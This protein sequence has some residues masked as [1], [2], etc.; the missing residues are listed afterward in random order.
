M[1]ALCVTSVKTIGMKTNFVKQQ[2]VNSKHFLLLTFL[3]L[4]A[5]FVHRTMVT[6]ADSVAVTNLVTSTAAL[7]VLVLRTTRSA[8]PATPVG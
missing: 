4:T 5:F 8:S 1:K 6:L 7:Q 3:L 2:V